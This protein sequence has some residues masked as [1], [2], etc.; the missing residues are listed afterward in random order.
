MQQITTV[1]PANKTRTTTKNILES[2]SKMYEGV[3]DSG[4][5]SRAPEYRQ[6]S[7]EAPPTGEVDWSFGEGG[8]IAVQA[9]HIKVVGGDHDSIDS[10]RIKCD[11]FCPE[12]C[13]NDMLR[14]ENFKE[15]SDEDMDR[16]YIVSINDRDDT[17]FVEKKDHSEF[18]VFIKHRC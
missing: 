8:T 13:I 16:D 1:I 3:E 7:H 2:Y 15:L 10:R 5:A 14:G 18:F 4:E 11:T 6:H 12:C 9:A 17:I